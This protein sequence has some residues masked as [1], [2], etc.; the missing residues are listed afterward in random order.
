M[1]VV[2]EVEIFLEWLL[3]LETE[4][5]LAIA[6]MGMVGFLVFAI[7]S[8]NVT[9]SFSKKV[10]PKHTNGGANVTTAMGA[11]SHMAESVQAL[12][13]DSAKSIA[14]MGAAVSALNE[15]VTAIKED[16]PKTLRSAVVDG[17]AQAVT[18]MNDTDE[19]RIERLHNDL[20]TI[21]QA[22]AELGRKI[23]QQFTDIGKR[24][25]GI[26]TQIL[27]LRADVENIKGD[28]RW[29][30]IIQGI[31]MVQQELAEKKPELLPTDAPAT[32]TQPLRPVEGRSEGAETVKTQKSEEKAAPGT[33]SAQEKAPAVE[34]SGPGLENR[35][36]D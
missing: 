14:Q 11:I 29:G 34:E 10:K 19:K 25:A 20:E 15:G 6:L 33:A 16:L 17:I 9:L 12:A 13:S 22:V 18:V 2:D 7:I 5:A 27:R 26:E 8:P 4:T 28:Q 35:K 24:V 1:P 30:E 36:S 3:D 23:D 21:T 31:A 32:Q